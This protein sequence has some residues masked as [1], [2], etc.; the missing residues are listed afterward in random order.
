MQPFTAIFLSLGVILFVQSIF[1]TLWLYFCQPSRFKSIYQ[2]S[3]ILGALI[4]LALAVFGLA[5]YMAISKTK[6]KKDDDV[7]L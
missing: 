6:K 2:L 3:A 4:V 1:L 5:I 7:E